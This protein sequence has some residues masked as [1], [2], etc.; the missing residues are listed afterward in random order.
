[1]FYF[2]NF[3]VKLLLMCKIYCKLLKFCYLRNNEYVF[4][5]HIFFKY[6]CKHLFVFSEFY[7]VIVFYFKRLCNVFFIKINSCVWMKPWIGIQ[8]VIIS[9]NNNIIQRTD[10]SCRLEINYVPPKGLFVYTVQ[11]QKMDYDSS[12]YFTRHDNIKLN[13][14][15]CLT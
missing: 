15:L 9:V 8:S 6:K 14:R 11:K 3:I 5:V 10:F 12:I 4:Y 13:F 1:M 2:L 7:F